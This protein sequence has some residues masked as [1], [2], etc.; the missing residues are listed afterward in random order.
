MTEA[1][2][3]PDHLDIALR[4]NNLAAANRAADRSA[5]AEALERRAPTN[6]GFEPPGQGLFLARWGFGCCERLR[7]STP[8]WKT[9]PKQAA[10]I[11]HNPLIPGSQNMSQPPEWMICALLRCEILRPAGVRNRR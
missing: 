2:F 8:N 6:K 9:K 7:S 3:G 4:L 5:D 11:I 10:I 1:A